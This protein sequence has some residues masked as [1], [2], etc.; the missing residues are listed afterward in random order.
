MLKEAGLPV[1]ML[2]GDKV[3]TACCIAM[4]CGLVAKGQ[5]LFKIT[6]ENDLTRIE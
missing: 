1:W 3:E 5:K 4:S 2:T 6:G